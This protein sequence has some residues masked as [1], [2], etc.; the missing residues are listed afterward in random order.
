MTVSELKKILDGYPDDMEVTIQVP[1]YWEGD[2]DYIAPN[3]QVQF[4]KLVL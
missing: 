2:V 4:E 3:P 1:E